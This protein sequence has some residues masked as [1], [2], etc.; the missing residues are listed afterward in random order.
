MTSPPPFDPEEWVPV[1]R[2]SRSADT[3]DTASFARALEQHPRVLVEPRARPY[4][5]RARDL[6]LESGL[7]Y[8]VLIPGQRKL[9]GL[10]RD[11]VIHTI[12]PNATDRRGAHEFGN[13]NAVHFFSLDWGARDVEIS[14]L[15]FVGEGPVVTPA[16]WELNNLMSVL[17]LPWER[18]RAGHAPENV[19]I[20]RCHFERHFGFPTVQPGGGSGI[21]YVENTHTD[22][23]NGP[24]LNAD[25][26]VALR[27]RFLRSEGFE[28]SESFGW[29]LDNE[30]KDVW[31]AFSIGGNQSDRGSPVSRSVVVRRN[32]IDGVVWM[33]SMD[34][35]AAA[36]AVAD[37]VEEVVLEENTVTRTAGMGILVKSESPDRRPI[38]T[39]RIT[40]NT[41]LAIGLRGDPTRPVGRRENRAGPFSIYVAGADDVEISGNAM[42]DQLPG[43][44]PGPYGSYAGVRA[45]GSGR[46]LRIGPNNIM[47]R[48]RRYWIDADYRAVEWLDGERP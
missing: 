37:N 9:R 25:R 6:H 35:P 26:V 14:D 36:I 20:R 3:D 42:A 5:V 32:T 47:V 28:C 34:A 13:R 12:L 41:L 23:M 27:N 18:G 7:R 44:N 16:N 21:D 22:C 46:G 17:H 4:V 11:S 19:I 1:G 40:R 10:G 31:Q 29:Y 30:F 33:Y 8:G 43:D 24:N 38:R 45:T 2:Y 15:T 39:V 48:G